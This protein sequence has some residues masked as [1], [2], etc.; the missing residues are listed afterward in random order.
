V[1]WLQ[2]GLVATQ[3]LVT[4]L[5]NELSRASV[6]PNVRKAALSVLS[7]MCSKNPTGTPQNACGA[8]AMRCDT[9]QR[10][11]VESPVSCRVVS[12]VQR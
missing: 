10:R 4:Y 7:Q 5:L 12:V 9:L 2:I 8:S 3:A 6:T 11:R 1:L